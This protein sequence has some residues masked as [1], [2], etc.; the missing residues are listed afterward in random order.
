MIR[1]SKDTNDKKAVLSQRLPRNAT[2]VNKHKQPHLHL[3]SRDSRMNV[4]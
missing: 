2:K 4:T 1:H 3:R